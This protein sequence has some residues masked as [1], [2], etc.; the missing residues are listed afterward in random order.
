MQSKNWRC[1]DFLVGVLR[2]ASIWVSDVRFCIGVSRPISNRYRIQKKRRMLPGFLGGSSQI[3]FYMSFGCEILDRSLQTDIKPKQNPKQK[4]LLM[5]LLGCRERSDSL[6]WL[7]DSIQSKSS[8]CLDSWD[9]ALRLASMSFRFEI[10]GRRFRTDGAEKGNPWRETGHMV[11]PIWN[12]YRTDMKVEFAVKI[13]AKPTWKQKLV[14]ARSALHQYTR[15]T[16]SVPNKSAS[17]YIYSGF[18]LVRKSRISV[19]HGSMSLDMVSK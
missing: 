4:L 7:S 9:A 14:G 12:R 1:L 19:W 13:I 16:E 17:S 18:I 11:G 2:L 5:G 10:L 6:L 15:S 8:C 3:C